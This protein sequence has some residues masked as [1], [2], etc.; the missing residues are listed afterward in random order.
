MK[1]GIL[2]GSRNYYK[3][4]ID[5]CEEL[6]IDYEVRDN[7]S[8]GY[9]GIGK[10]ELLATGSGTVLFTEEIRICFNYIFVVIKKRRFIFSIIR[11][12]YIFGDWFSLILV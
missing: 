4:Y 5:S 10:I 2:T 8:D 3:K 11:F 7:P 6:N 12:F 9:S 1:L